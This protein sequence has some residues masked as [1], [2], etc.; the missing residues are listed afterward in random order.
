MNK[1]ISYVVEYINESREKRSEVCRLVFLNRTKKITLVAKF[2]Y[3]IVYSEQNA[4]FFIH[5]YDCVRRFHMRVAE[6]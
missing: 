1:E 5:T 3:F 6:G 2:H 4:W